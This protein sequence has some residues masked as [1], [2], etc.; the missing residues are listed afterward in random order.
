[1]ILKPAKFGEASCE[2]FGLLRG[3][4]VIGIAAT[5][6]ETKMFHI[7]PSSNLG[8]HREDM[9]I[10]RSTQRSEKLL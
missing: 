6:I 8:L 10:A 9:Q 5:G 4:D 1:M 7:G 3:Q 2:Q